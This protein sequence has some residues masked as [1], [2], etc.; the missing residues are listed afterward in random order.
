MTVSAK[1]KIRQF[2][3][4]PVFGTSLRRR[5]LGG[6]GAAPHQVLLQRLRAGTLRGVEAEFIRRVVNAV[7]ATQPISVA[8]ARR[9]AVASLPMALVARLTASH[10]SMAEAAQ[11]RALAPE[12]AAAYLSGQLS[13]AAMLRLLPVA[14]AMQ[15]VKQRGETIQACLDAWG[16]ALREQAELDKQASRRHQQAAA[17]QGRVQRHR[18]DETAHIQALGEHGRLQRR[19][20]IM[21]RN[22]AI[23]AATAATVV[24]TGEAGGALPQAVD[25]WSSV[26]AAP[27][28]ADFAPRPAEPSHQ[29]RLGAGLRRRPLDA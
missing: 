15:I 5:T 26:W 17:E 2:P 7:R 11:I 16:K 10:G 3:T 22:A 28:P 20:L 13:F 1:N 12:H 14:I 25:S 4:K 8:A 29:A 23:L 6:Q 18:E 21:D 27:R 9:L 24:P 19:A